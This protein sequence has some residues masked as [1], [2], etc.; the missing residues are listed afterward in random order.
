[1]LTK[2]TGVIPQSPSQRLVSYFSSKKK[3]QFVTWQL[4][5]MTHMA[6]KNGS[7]A[8]RVDSHGSHAGVTDLSTS[9]CS[10]PA[11]QPEAVRIH[12]CILWGCALLSVVPL[13]IVWTLLMLFMDSLTCSVTNP[14]RW[15]AFADS[16]GGLVRF[17][18]LEAQRVCPV[19][20]SAV[21][22]GLTKW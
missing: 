3:I 12:L 10:S 1:M 19:T 18:Y 11:K 15:L 21:N 20:E 22:G 4:F 9:R 14:S 13:R 8:S 17:H 7:H 5:Y 6:R 16:S 2:N